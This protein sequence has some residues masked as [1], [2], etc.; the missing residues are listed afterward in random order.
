M[1][2]KWNVMKN[3]PLNEKNVYFTYHGYRFIAEW[4]SKENVFHNESR[5]R[6]K[7]L[8]AKRVL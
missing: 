8:S 7:S 2:A 6:W 4:D 5:L 3:K 1:K